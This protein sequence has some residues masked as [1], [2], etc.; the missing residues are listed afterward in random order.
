MG[1][2]QH[3]NP[4]LHWKH[5]RRHSYTALWTAILQTLFMLVAEIFWPGIV[6]RLAPMIGPAYTFCGFIVLAYIANCAVEAW[7][8]KKW[9]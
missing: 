7:I 6:G 4:L 8:G 5:R 2:D 1:D 3:P 9:Q